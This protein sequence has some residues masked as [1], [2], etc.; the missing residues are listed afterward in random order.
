VA[1]LRHLLGNPGLLQRMIALGRQAFDGGDLLA[2]DIADSGLAGP[3]RL[4][5]DVNRACSAQ[6]RAA[7][8]LR[9]GHLQLLADGPQQR[10]IVRRLHGHIPSVDV[11]SNHMF[12]PL[13]VREATYGS[14][15]LFRQLAPTGSVPALSKRMIG[16]RHSGNPIW[17]WARRINFRTFWNCGNRAASCFDNPPPKA[18]RVGGARKARKVGIKG[19]PTL[20]R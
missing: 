5:I 6:A 8:E 9:A 18:I 1:A 14:S 20:D 4:A 15:S 16:F 2:D 11:E 12:L 3:Y 17:N 13:P 10:R 7:A 19:M